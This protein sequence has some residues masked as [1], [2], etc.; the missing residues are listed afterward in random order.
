MKI[1]FLSDNFPPEVNAASSRVYERACYWVKENNKVTVMTCAPN[2]PFGK[3]FEGYKNKWVQKEKIEGIQVIRVKTFMAPN[4]GFALRI[5]DFLSYM[6]M[7]IIVGTFQPKPDV[8]IAT[9]PQ[10]FA[11]VGGWI[12]SR[13][14]RVPFVFEIGDLWPE[15]IKGLGLMGDSFIYKTLEK[16]ELFLYRHSEA[17]VA[18]TYAFKENLVKRGIDPNKI[19]VI[20]NGVDIN[21]YK[22][23]LKKDEE[24]IHEYKLEKKFIL[25]YIGT[26]G[27]SH[28]LKHIID[29]AKLI[30]EKNKDI[31]FIFVGDGSEKEELVQ[32]TK[33]NR[34]E[35][36]LFIPLQPKS[37]IQKWWSIC[38]VALVPLKDLDVFRTVIPSKIFEASAMGL[39]LVLIAPEGEASQLLKKEKFGIH[40]LPKNPQALAQQLID[41]SKNIVLQENLKLA[42]LKIS[43]LYSREKQAKEFIDYLKIKIS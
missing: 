14:K 6:V 9:S 25:G 38:D 2:F 32:H 3:L 41:L 42:S 17:I 26:H 37:K 30:E 16:I 21:K 20:L 36:V 22:P 29:V 39:P 10:F 13:I 35:N 27:M 31:F 33:I 7:A 28:N 43:K 4:K 12:L 19:K 34:I 11:A 1:L 5:L 15:S 24:I 23:F 40:V 18:Q 8:I